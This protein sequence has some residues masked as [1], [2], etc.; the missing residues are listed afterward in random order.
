M[1]CALPHLETLTCTVPCPWRNSI[2]DVLISVIWYLRNLSPFQVCVTYLHQHYF[3]CLSLSCI[4]WSTSWGQ[5]FYVSCE[6]FSGLSKI[7]SDTCEYSE[8]GDH[9]YSYLIIENKESKNPEYLFLTTCSWVVRPHGQRLLLLRIFLEMQYFRP[10]F[11][12]WV[13]ICIFTDP[14]VIGALKCEKPGSS[15][16]ELPSTLAFSSEYRSNTSQGE[17]IPWLLL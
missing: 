6:F 11:R 4:R 15:F 1:W 3:N 8:L 16:L 17:R 7:M 9:P 10:Q 5:E 14:Q 2:P 12:E 13:R